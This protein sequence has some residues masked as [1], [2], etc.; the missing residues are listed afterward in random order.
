MND[1]IPGSV[2]LAKTG[3]VPPVP[4]K[5]SVGES[6]HLSEGVEPRVQNAEKA[7]EQ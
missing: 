3:G 1:N 4:V 6:Q 5:L 7:N 2:K